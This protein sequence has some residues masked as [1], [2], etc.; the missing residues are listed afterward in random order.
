[1]STCNCLKKSEMSQCEK[2][3]SLEDVEEE[4]RTGLHSVLRVM[5]NSCSRLTEVATGS[6]HAVYD[7]AKPFVKA[8]IHNNVTTNAVLGEC[9][10]FNILSSY[11]LRYFLL[12]YLHLI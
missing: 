11:V 12:H 5:C 2:V 1:M 10:Y 3:L 8:N 7:N 9:Y 4:K 6:K